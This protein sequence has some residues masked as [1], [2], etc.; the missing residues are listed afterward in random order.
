MTDSPLSIWQKYKKT[1]GSTRPWDL[2]DSTQPRASDEVATK[3]LKICNDCPKLT[4]FT[5]QCKV[6]LCFMNLKVKLAGAECPEG[7]WHAENPE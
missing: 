6:C 5:Q 7:K 3:R 1:L 2:L 4:K